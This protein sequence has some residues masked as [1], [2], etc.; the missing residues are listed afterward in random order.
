MLIGLQFSNITGLAIA[1][2]T[3][4]L[5]GKTPLFSET[6]S[7]R[8]RLHNLIIQ[9]FLYSKLFINFCVIRSQTA[10]T[11]ETVTLG[12]RLGLRGHNTQSV[13]RNATRASTHDWKTYRK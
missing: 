3:K 9:L 7:L 12:A 1:Q 8:F 6:D 5:D 10:A 11:M 13:V 2:F 4:T